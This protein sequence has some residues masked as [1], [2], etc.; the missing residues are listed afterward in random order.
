MLRTGNVVTRDG[1]SAI[2][3]FK[4]CSDQALEGDTDHDDVLDV[5]DDFIVT[6]SFD[7][8]ID[9]SNS[10]KHQ[11]KDGNDTDGD[12]PAGLVK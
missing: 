11:P 9:R 7:S 12:G 2:V 10:S 8:L 6:C 5:D 4:G 3:S 1:N